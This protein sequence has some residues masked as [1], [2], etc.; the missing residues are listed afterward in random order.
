NQDVNATIMFGEKT[1]EVTG[2][3][4]DTAG[5]P[6]SDYTIVLFAS[7]KSFWVPN[8]RRI[9]TVRP[10]TDGKFNFTNLP[11]GDYKLTAVTDI[12][13]GEQFDPNFLEQLVNSG[14][15]VV[16]REGEKKVQDIKGQ[17]GGG[18]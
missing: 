5:A 13:P 16:L 17:A 3:I 6:T 15:P 11:V 14:V 9:R 18:H 2:T 10:G 8:A 1:Q 7:D 12:E 4:Q